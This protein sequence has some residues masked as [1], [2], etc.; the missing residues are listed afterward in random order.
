VK[1][2]IAERTLDIDGYG[3]VEFPL[4]PFSAYCLTRGIDQLDFILQ[5]ADD[6]SQYEQQHGK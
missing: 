2:D 5:G 4:D 1:I 3:T 6:I